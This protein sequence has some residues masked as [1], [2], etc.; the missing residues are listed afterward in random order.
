MFIDS[1]NNQFIIGDITLSLL[2]FTLIANNDL[3]LKAY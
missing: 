1:R 2:V 3:K